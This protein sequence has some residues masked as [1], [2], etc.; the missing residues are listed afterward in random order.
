MEGWQLLGQVPAKPTSG[1]EKRMMTNARD[2]IGGCD[3]RGDHPGGFLSGL[4][5]DQPA[6]QKSQDLL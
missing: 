3:H 5:E 4:A 1:S 2:A 6:L